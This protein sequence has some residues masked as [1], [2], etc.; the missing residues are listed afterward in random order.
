[1]KALFPRATLCALLLAAPAAADT[2]KLEGGTVIDNVKVT[3]ESWKEIEY[4]KPRVSSVQ[5]V[6]SSKV[7]SVEYSS[8]T[9]DF[10]EAL[11]KQEEGE[12]TTSA[13]YFEAVASDESAPKFLRAFS[14]AR[15]GDNLLENGNLSDAT[16]AYDRLLK[17]HADTRHFGRAL[18]GK[19]K[20]L[21]GERKFDEAARA[22]ETLLKEVETKAL[23]E[24]VK[25]EAEFYALLASEAQGKSAEAE[26]GYAALRDRVAK[27]HRGI[28][29]R[30]TL[31][32]ARLKLAAGDVAAALPLYEE[33]LD[34]RLEIDR[35]IVAEAFNGRGRCHFAKA[36]AE[37]E[38]SQKAGAGGDSARAEQYRANALAAFAE[39]RLDFLRVVVSY[40]AVQG[41]QPEALYWAAQCWSNTDDEDAAVQAAR[42]LKTCAVRYPNSEWGKRAAQ[43]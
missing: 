29:G 42:L 17:E 8:T 35:D 4:R 2:I 34:E 41:Q 27:T 30:C 5:K 36:Q 21:L 33:I 9:A 24:Q 40:P 3:A 19:G 6:E 14:L 11:A 7:V 16:Q 20:A 43:G 39:A 18:L 32:L 37:L 1:M 26:K 31:R 13:A 23:G 12:L 25:V 38:R 10:R 22:F 15:M 28:A